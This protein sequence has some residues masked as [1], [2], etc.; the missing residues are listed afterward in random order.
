ML[1]RLLFDDLFSFYLTETI[2]LFIIIGALFLFLFAREKTGEALLG[3]LKSIASFFY[4]PF[5]F[6]K[7]AILELAEFANRKEESYQGSKQYLLNKILIL[8]QTFLIIISTLILAQG[9]ITSWNAFLP[10]K[11]IRDSISATEDNLDANKKRQDE[12]SPAIEKMDNEWNS[13]R[14]QLVKDFKSDRQKQINQSQSNNT[15]IENDL[16]NENSVNQL[17]FSIK[18]H[19]SQNETSG[20]S[21]LERVKND[22][23]EYINRQNISES[24]KTS[25]LNYIN[26]WNIVL[27]SQFELN[28]LSESNLRNSVQPDYNRLKEEQDGII[29]GITSLESNLMQLKTQA[30]Y[31]LDLFLLGLLVTLLTF[32]LYIWIIGILIELL[33][34]S[35]DIASN[36]RAIKNQT[37]AN[38]YDVP[39]KLDNNLRWKNLKL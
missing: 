10:P 12:I 39:Q 20:T 33:W 14:E 6:I 29:R 38:E 11:Y 19:L 15:K 26:N 23:I 3:I 7:N 30:K 31:N 32:V 8:S 28:N 37:K 25:L 27:Q 9:V 16:S 24:Y 2:I 4:S 18:N 5:I 1:N 35:V 22:A 13:K 36:L 34:L 17:F 21:R